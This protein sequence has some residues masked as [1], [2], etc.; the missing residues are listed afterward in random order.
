[1]RYV[2]SLEVI[3]DGSRAETSDGTSVAGAFATR[4]VEA[5]SSI[6]AMELAEKALK[7]EVIDELSWR[8]FEIEVRDMKP[9]SKWAFF[10]KRKPSGFTFYSD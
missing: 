3:A 8:R 9:V 5:P 6:I 4:V 1:M 2:V 7:Q 10:F